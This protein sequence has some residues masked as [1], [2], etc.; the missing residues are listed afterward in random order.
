MQPNFQFCAESHIPP[1]AENL[2]EAMLLRSD[3]GYKRPASCVIFRG[4]LRPERFTGALM[5]NITRGTI[6]LKDVS[7][8][9][10]LPL[11]FKR[12]R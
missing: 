12:R 3:I 4:R 6:C 2:R 8:W 5:P 11:F 10:V 1:A 7:L 9:L